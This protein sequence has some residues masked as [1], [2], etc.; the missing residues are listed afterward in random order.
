ML[1]YGDG[2]A[3]VD[4]DALVSFHKKHGRALTM[5]TVQPE[6]RFGSI[7]FGS[8]GLVREFKEKPPGDNTWINAGFMVCEPRVFD[9]LIDGD[10]TVFERSPLESLARSGELMAFRHGGFWKC[11]DTLRDKKLLNEL[12]DEGRAAWAIW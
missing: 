9:F 7:D 3:D 8:D 12:W 1:T 10:Q 6:G 11:M 2:V 5:T 4:I